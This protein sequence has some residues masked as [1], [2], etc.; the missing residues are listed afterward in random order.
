MMHVL[1]TCTATSVPHARVR[2]ARIT[3]VALASTYAGQ[4][5][6]TLVDALDTALGQVRVHRYSSRCF[7]NVT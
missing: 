2:T 7:T 1:H 4:A 3:Q 6:S 5:I